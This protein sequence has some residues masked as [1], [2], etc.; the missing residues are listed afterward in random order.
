MNIYR[1]VE[2]N[3]MDY[4]AEKQRINLNS[5]KLMAETL[6]YTCL[7][8]NIILRRL[9][10]IGKRLMMWLS[11]SKRWAKWNGAGPFSLLSNH[12]P[13]TSPESSQ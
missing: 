2:R 11:H 8:A 9:P 6:G 5:R 12:L 7:E 1:V 4:E 3:I 10:P 13:P